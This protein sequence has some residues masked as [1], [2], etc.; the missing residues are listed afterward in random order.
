MQTPATQDLRIHPALLRQARQPTERETLNAAHYARGGL[1]AV[2]FEGRSLTTL[3]AEMLLSDLSELS[4][5]TQRQADY[6]RHAALR[7]T[8]VRE[9]RAS[10]KARLAVKLA[11]AAAAQAGRRDAA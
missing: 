7:N 9:H 8:I 11:E 4:K 2:E 5:A 1:T 3:A 10:I 6:A